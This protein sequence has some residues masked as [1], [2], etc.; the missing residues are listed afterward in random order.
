MLRTV[1]ICGYALG[2]QDLTLISLELGLLDKVGD[3]AGQLEDN[4]HCV[5]PSRN[6]LACPKAML[7]KLCQLDN[8][9]LTV[10]SSLAWH[11]CESQQHPIS[12]APKHQSFLQSQSR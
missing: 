10:L 3:P 5:G 8:S 9:T 4:D 12:A 6:D 1:R 2:S 11:P 7:V